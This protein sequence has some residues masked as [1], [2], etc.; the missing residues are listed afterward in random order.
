M[1]LIARVVIVDDDPFVRSGLRTI[2]ESDQIMVVG[3]A[4]DGDDALM[5]VDSEHPDLVLLDI[6]MPRVDGISVTRTLRER[7]DTTRVLIMTTFDSDEF[8]MEAL[9]AGANG[10]LLKDTRPADIITAIHK[11]I[12]GDPVLSPAATA[13]LISRVTAEPHARVSRAYRLVATLTDR[14]RDVA[15]GIAEGRTNQQI[16]QALHV[17]VNTVKTHISALFA[18]LG[19][20][21]RVDIARTI[22][23]A[24]TDG[25]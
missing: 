14:E 12:A 25:P 24:R 22:F 20:K 1:E 16:A 21:N 2:I 17:S 6:R 23:E 11:T 9:R 7:G 18:K 8:V 5:L 3:E 19:A 13:R 4:S 10:F 15:L